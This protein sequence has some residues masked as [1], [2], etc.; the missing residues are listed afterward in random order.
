MSPQSNKTFLSLEGLR[1]V[2]CIA[3]VAYHYVFYL[4]GQLHLWTQKFGIAVDLFFVISE[5]VIGA[6]YIGRV[7]ELDEYADFIRR[8]FAR[9]YPLHLA[10]LAFYVCVG[11]GVSFGGLQVID[12]SRYNFSELLPNL[13]MVHAWGFSS[14]LSF[15]YVSWSISAEMFLYL[16]FPFILFVMALGM[17]V[18]LG[19][20][21]LA[22]GGAIFISH[23]VFGS[24]LTEL[25]AGQ[26][27][28]IRAGPSFAFGVWLYFHRDQ[29]FCSDQQSLAYRR[30]PW[31]FCGASGLCRIPG[32]RLYSA[33]DGLSRRGNCPCMRRRGI[34]TFA[35]WSRLS[36][37]GC[38]TYS[39]YMLHLVM[40]SIIIRFLVPRLLGESSATMVAGVVISAGAMFG[41]A[42]LSYRFFENPLRHMIN[43]ISLRRN[44]NN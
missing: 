31:L 40:A 38:L 13:L 6:T 7:R 14:H 3:I 15:N 33:D 19:T 23:V 4:P 21:I 39:V 24:P 25:G 20:V 42:M 2:S 32:K 37:L 30:L 8:R 12:A 34:P 26:L 27:A 22:F 5:V 9:L 1:F 10:T 28:I 35:S 29:T 18:S 44:E 11:L 17:I 43:A 41:A 16:I 36:S